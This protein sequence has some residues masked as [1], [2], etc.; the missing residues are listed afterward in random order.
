MYD[1]DSGSAAGAMISLSVVVM[2]CAG[3]D[4]G[5][6]AVFTKDDDDDCCLCVVVL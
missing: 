2:G 6:L 5:T 1:D 4:I 3:V